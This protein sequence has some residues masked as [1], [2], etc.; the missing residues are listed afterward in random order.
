MTAPTESSRS[1]AVLLLLFV[2]VALVIAIA[3]LGQD[4][5]SVGG[6]GDP[7]GT[8]PDGLLALR[9]LVEETGG[10]TIRNLGLP[11]DEV[12]VAIL[13]FPPTP[14]I[15]FQD[16]EA[17]IPEPN[18]EPLLNWVD[19][20]GVLITSVDVDGGPLTGA[21]EDDEDA[22]LE[23]GIC[24]IGDLAGVDEL[25]PRAYQ[26]VI[27]INEDTQCFGGASGSAVV[28]R[29]FGDGR[30]VRLGSIGAFTNLALDDADNGAFAARL[31]ALETAPT[32]GFMSRAPVFFQ[33]D[34]DGEVVLDGEGAPIEQLSP[35][36]SDQ[37]LDSEGNPIGSGD[38]GLLDLVPRSVIAMILALAASLLLYTLAR[39]RRLGSPIEEP[40]PIELPSSSYVEAVGRSFARV[41]N[42]P[43]RSA[44][45]LRS[46]LRAE[47]SRRVGLP[48]DTPTAELVQAFGG[49]SE[50]A[51]LLDGEPGTDEDLLVTAT[52]LVETRS[53]MERG[54]V[55]VLS[56]SETLG[57]SPIARDSA[58]TARKDIS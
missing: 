14:P 9:L 6:P 33:I 10:T 50:L 44:T 49:D 8:G 11:T 55:S 32:V 43:N 36:A 46:D 3:F 54:G 20:G 41:S 29:P 31:L 12:D 45:I 7:D 58:S 53:R 48:V 22:I 39:G 17:E 52:E 15:N 4:E 34:D 57:Q 1:S 47:I 56:R 25:R 27:A 37:P 13:A 16:P 18:W 21:L 28:L 19:R 51:R 23:R 26:R 35:F 5:Q 38:S 40:L 42:A 30:I 24:N 2:V